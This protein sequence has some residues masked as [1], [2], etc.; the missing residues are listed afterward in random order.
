MRLVWQGIPECL[1]YTSSPGNILGLT[2]PPA[3]IWQ[4]IPECLCYTGDPGNILGLPHP[5]I[6]HPSSRV[7]RNAGVTLT[8]PGLSYQ[9]QSTSLK[10]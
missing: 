3:P 9:P 8:L 10:V 2:H 5:P 1:S 6:Q 4:S 7:S